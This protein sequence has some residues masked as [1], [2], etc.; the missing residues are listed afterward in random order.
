MPGLLVSMDHLFT[1]LGIGNEDMMK[2]SL[3]QEGKGKND[4]S[5]TMI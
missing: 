2:R 4:F 5:R 3:I 1:F